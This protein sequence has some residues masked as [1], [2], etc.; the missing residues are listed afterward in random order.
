MAQWL[1]IGLAMQGTGVGCPGRIPCA[2][3]QLSPPTTTRDP[4]CARKGPTGRNE[5][6]RCC[7]YD[8][9]QPSKDISVL[10]A[11]HTKK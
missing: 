8:R 3:E 2:T 4:V 1:R 5:D 10:S 9:T 7:S 6:L 11:K